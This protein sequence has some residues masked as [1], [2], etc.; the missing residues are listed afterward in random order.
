MHNKFKKREKLNSQVDLNPEILEEED[1][2]FNRIN[3]IL[4]KKK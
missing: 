1:D 4:S 2:F 3:D